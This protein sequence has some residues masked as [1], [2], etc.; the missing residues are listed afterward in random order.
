VPL[1]GNLTLGVAALSYN[2][3]LSLGVTADTDA[4]PDVDAFVAGVEQSFAQLGAIP[5]VAARRVG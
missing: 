1:S 4:C 5:N 3:A 2:G